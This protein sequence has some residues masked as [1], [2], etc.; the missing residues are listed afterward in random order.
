MTKDMRHSPPRQQLEQSDQDQPG[1][2]DQPHG[3]EPDSATPTHQKAHRRVGSATL[4]AAGLAVAMASGGVGAAVALAVQA[5]DSTISIVATA[6]VAGAAAPQLGASLP[7]DSIEQ[8]AATVLPSVV[9]LKIDLGSQAEQGSGI[10]LTADELIMTNAHV[11]A[12]ATADPAGS[13]PARALV[14]LADDRTAPFSVVASDPTTD[15]ALV[16]AQGVSALTPITLGVSNNLRVGQQVV[17]VGC[18]LGLEGTVTSGV[19]SALHRPVSTADSADHATPRDT[20]Q[21]DAPINPGNSG[22]AL[23]DMNGQLIGMISAIATLDDSPYAQSGSIGL[24]FAIPVD[25]AKRIANELIATGKASHASLGVQV[26][27]NAHIPGARIVEVTSA[28]PAAAAGLR[29]GAVITKFDDR[30]IDS[31]DA[32]V[33][34]VRSNAPGTTVTLQYLDPSGATGTVDATLGTDQGLTDPGPH[35]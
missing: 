9:Q 22:G 28:G 21:T 4:Y 33:A 15:V 3:R 26:D 27:D 35:P 20:I 8:V 2:P 32:L 34:A 12:A 6:A 25:Q 23:V 31:A 11:V 30:P 7:A 16:R 5:H 10:I 29:T 13:G 19:I 1:G 18:P 17:A 24:G 14:T